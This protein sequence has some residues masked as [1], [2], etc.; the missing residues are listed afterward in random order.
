M[1]RSKI[2]LMVI[3]MN[4]WKFSKF[5]KDNA[6]LYQIPSF[7]DTGLVNHGFTTRIGGVS[8]QP[9]KSLNLG[10][11]TK[12]HHEDILKNYRIVCGCLNIDAENVVLSD[13]V[14]KDRM[15]VADESHRGNGLLHKNKFPE[16][17][18]LITNRKN[19]A[20]VTHY[21]D[22]VPIFILDT[23]QSVIALAHGGWKGTALKIGAKVIRKMMDDFDTNSKDCLIGIGPSIGRCCYE[24]DDY[25]INQF[26]KSYGDVT[27]FVKEK[28]D[29]KYDLD[30]WK[31]NE[32]SLLEVGVPAENI[33]ISN[34]CTKC[35]NDLF[36]SYRAENGNTG[37]M[38]A[39]LQLI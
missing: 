25:V 16:I 4:N 9:Y 24:V 37:R 39:I 32:I 19:V 8:K 5:E 10:V 17:D 20:L 35:N 13:Q 1:A 33:T 38:A 28:G 22:C 12:D 3:E 27:S 14:H 6:V 21:A 7:E 11:N 2:I 15:L 31:A 30:L 34:M 18:A 36:Y 29:G 26:K 23:R